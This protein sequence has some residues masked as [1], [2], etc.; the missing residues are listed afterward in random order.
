M[1]EIVNFQRKK[2]PNREELALRKLKVMKTYVGINVFR[3][4]DSR[5][6]RKC[7]KWLEK[8]KKHKKT[9]KTLVNRTTTKSIEIMSECMLNL[10][11]DNS[12][13]L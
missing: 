13:N 8:K 2:L 1:N 6:N 12:K 5:K 3:K 9:D 11:V 10:W 4:Q 7:R